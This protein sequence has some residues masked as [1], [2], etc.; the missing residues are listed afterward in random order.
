MA[1]FDGEHLY[2]YRLPSIDN[3]VAHE[4]AKKKWGSLTITGP[5]SID[6][7]TAQ[8]LAQFRGDMLSLDDL[9][10]IDEEAAQELER[11]KGYL[12]L[13]RKNLIQNTTTQQST[14]NKNKPIEMVNDP[15]QMQ[16]QSLKNSGGDTV[17]KGV[18][19]IEPNL[20][21]IIGEV[22]GWIT[23]WDQ[24]VNTFETKGTDR[25][26]EAS[27]NLIQAQLERGELR[28]IE[29]APSRYTAKLLKAHLEKWS[30]KRYYDTLEYGQ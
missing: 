7:E 5:R 19:T 4:L 22:D 11:F 6:R 29:R 16:V 25:W 14:D 20:R 27:N 28:Q 18:S 3:E 24:R 21:T 2:F 26:M 23:H 17:R 12:S 30:K 15:Q 9:A 8:E 1:K 13:D 10:S